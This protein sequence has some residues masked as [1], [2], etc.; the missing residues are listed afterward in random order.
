MQLWNNRSFVVLFIAVFVLF[1]VIVVFSDLT[2]AQELGELSI[3]IWDYDQE[4]YMEEYLFFEGGAYGVDVWYVDSN[5]LADN[6]TVTMP[7]KT[8]IY[9]PE[10]LPEDDKMIPVDVPRFE[11]YPDGFDITANKEGCLGDVI[12]VMIS[13][14]E[15]RVDTDRDTIEETKS[16]LVTVTDQ[17][18]K[19]IADAIVEIDGIIK[20]TT[21]VGGRAFIEAPEVDADIEVTVDVYKMGYESGSTSIFIEDISIIIEVDPILVAAALVIVAIVIVT[22]R[23]WRSRSRFPS[24]PKIPRVEEKPKVEKPVEGRPPSLKPDVHIREKPAHI[25]A[26]H[27]KDLPVKKR[28]SK[29]EEIRIQ[30]PGKPKETSVVSAEEKPRKRLF[31]RSR[32]QGYEWFEGTDDIRYKIDRLT[33][34]VDEDTVDKW[35]E[36]TGDVRSKIDEAIS[37]KHKKHKNKE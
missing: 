1:S 36:G 19:E 5:L 27:S 28:D 32:K 34:E 26:K 33:G 9:S 18:G 30:R 6:V 10:E 3:G 14:G 8:Y 13:K 15:L 4:T 25:E 11:E 31:R 16:F 24:K 17:N 23:Q 12:R 7:G 29:V 21:N 2:M 22:V 35:H 37:K 20:G